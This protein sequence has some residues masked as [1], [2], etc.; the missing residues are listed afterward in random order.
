MN[1]FWT[2]IIIKTTLQQKDEKLAKPK[3]Y[4]SFELAKGY[5][6]FIITFKRHIK[7]FFLIVI[8]IFSASFGFKGFLLSN[9]FIDGELRVFPYLFLS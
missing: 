8:G 4:S 2:R 3:G 1:P 9:H 6:E 5:R 7:D